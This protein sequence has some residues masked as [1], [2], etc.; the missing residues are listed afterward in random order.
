MSELVKQL[1]NEIEDKLNIYKREQI[2]NRCQKE[3]LFDILSLSNHS[4]QLLHKQSCGI[5][6]NTA[7]Y[8]DYYDDDKNKCEKCRKNICVECIGNYC[9]FHYYAWKIICKECLDEKNKSIICEYGKCDKIC[10]Y[11]CDG[12]IDCVNNDCFNEIKYEGCRG[13]NTINGLREC[14]DCEDLSKS[15]TL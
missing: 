9:D 12:K 2:I 8:T 7:F 4:N 11:E 15:S 1:V 6:Q 10:C 14:E 3:I 13:C 5:C